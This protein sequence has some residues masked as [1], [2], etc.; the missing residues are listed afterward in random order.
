LLQQLDIAGAVDKEFQ[1]VGGA[2]GTP[3]SAEARVSTRLCGADA[4][5]RVGFVNGRIRSTM[6]NRS[7]V[8]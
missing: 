4:L 3:G 2:G 8:E 5:V 1:E 6:I 7:E